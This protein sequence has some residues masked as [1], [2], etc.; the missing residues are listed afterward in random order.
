MYHFTI[1]LIAD[2]YYSF[3]LLAVS[4]KTCCK[5]FSFILRDPSH[6]EYECAVVKSLWPQLCRHINLAHL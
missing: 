2:N 6:S 3:S 5:M 1:H 4:M